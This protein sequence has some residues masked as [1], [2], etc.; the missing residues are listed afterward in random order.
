MASQEMSSK[1]KAV[2][3]VSGVL[4]VVAMMV[5]PGC[6]TAPLPSSRVS[7][8]SRKKSDFAFAKSAQPSRSEVVRRLGEPDAFIADRRVACYR[9]NTVTRRK[10]WLLLGIIPVGVVKLPGELDIAFI[11]FDE[12]DRVRRSGM[13]TGYPGA[14]LDFAAKRWLAAKEKGKPRH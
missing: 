3:L 11:E 4:W 8:L 2:L 5:W 6:A 10:L 7:I 14:G 1:A 9:V 12:H 13:G